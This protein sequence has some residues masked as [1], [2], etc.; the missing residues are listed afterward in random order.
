MSVSCVLIQI[1]I[2]SSIESPVAD[3]AVPFNTGRTVSDCC[4]L[5]P[6]LDCHDDSGKSSTIEVDMVDI[7]SVVFTWN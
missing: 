6:L 1:D 2:L 4:R 3:C 7:C 5:N